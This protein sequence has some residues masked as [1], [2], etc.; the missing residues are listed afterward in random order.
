MKSSDS[1]TGPGGIRLAY[2]DGRPAGT[3]R[4]TTIPENAPDRGHRYVL[5]VRGDSLLEDGILD[6]DFLVIEERTAARNGELIVVL[7]DS[8]ELMLRWYFRRRGRVLL[9]ADASDQ[10][11]VGDRARNTRLPRMEEPGMLIPAS[12]SAGSARRGRTRRRSR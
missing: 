9:E 1:S 8:D 7:L 3:R 12:T 11:G 4:T 2:F 5:K 6:G 10:G